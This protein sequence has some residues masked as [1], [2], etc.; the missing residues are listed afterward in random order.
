[1][2]D[3]VRVHRGAR[4][5]E[6]AL[7]AQVAELVAPIR[8]AR[9]FRG[10]TPLL[11]PYLA[12]PVRV[13]VPSRSLRE[14]VAARLAR[15][16]GG[17][18]VGV[19]VQTLRGLAFEIV[20]RAGE[21][22]R[23]GHVLFPILVRQLARDEEALRAALEDLDDGYSAVAASVS[24][25]LDAGYEPAL[26]EGLLDCLA[27][28]G[29]A[30]GERARALARVAGQAARRLADYG[31][32][33][34]AG[35]F[36][37]AREALEADAERLLHAR[38]I[39][40]HGYADATGVQ[41]E[42][43]RALRTLG[44]AEI[45]L[46]HPD[47][48]AEPGR[49]DPGH[50][51]TERLAS[52][53][54]LG[55]TA[56]E[57]AEVAPAP[58]IELFRA[59]GAQ[60][61][62]REVAERIRRAID[63][64]GAPEDLAI[65]ARD[66]GP[67]RLALETQ[68]GRLAIP[69]SGGRGSLTAAGRRLRALL[70]LLRD[71]A[72][73]AG[74]RWLDA[75]DLFDAAP[76]RDLRLALHG[77]GLGRVRDVAATDP[78]GVAGEYGYALPVR[79]GLFELEAEDG[80]D[81]D[82]AEAESTEVVAD[83]GAPGALPKR[84]AARAVRRRLRL[85]HLERAVER[86]AQLVDELDAL[87]GETTLGAI[88]ARLRRMLTGK[89]A[90]GWKPETAG[91]SEAHG[92]LAALEEEIGGGVALSFPEARLLLESALADAGR[93]PLGGA[94]G[95]VAILSVVEARARTF[96]R[97][98]VLGMNRD[99]FPRAIAEDP[100]LPDAD[101]VCIEA[102]LPDV[103][104]KRRGFTEERYLFAQLCSAAPHVCLSWQAVSDDGKE[105]LASPL[106]ERLLAGRADAEIPLAPPV[107]ARRGDAL[108]PAHEHAA[109][110]ALAGGRGVRLERLLA[111]SLAGGKPDA[112]ATLRAHARVAAIRELDEAGHRGLD[113]GPY[114]GFVGAIGDAAD[115]RSD[116][117]WVTALEGL[118][119]CGW[120]TFLRRVLRV[121]PVPDALEALP[122]IDARVIG[123]VLHAALEEIA[124]RA[125]VPAGVPLAE[126][127]A[128]EPRDVAWP[129]AAALDAI[130]LGAAE[131]VARE[132]GIALAGFPRDLDRRV[133][134]FLDRARALDWPAG[135]LRGVV[136]VELV[137]EARGA[138]GLAISFRADRVDRRAGALRLT[139][140]KAGKPFTTAKDAADRRE[141]LL[142]RIGGGTHL[143][144]F[145]YARGAGEDAALGRYLY[146]RPD[147]ADA[148]AEVAIEPRDAD[149]EARFESAAGALF[150]AY[151]QG[152]FAPRLLASNRKETR[153]DCTYCEVSAAC[154]QGSS[155]A[156]RR[157]ARWLE[158]HEEAAPGTPAEAAALAA[159]RLVDEER[160]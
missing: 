32:E 51:F 101:R 94:G 122:R 3:G 113:L 136:G 11:A 45:G 105:R 135:V 35:L 146:V 83:A 159:L 75:A 26:E 60:A 58:E 140:Y 157:L 117:L 68:L 107:V 28:L 4:A 92:A 27:G 67:Y 6:A 90:L 88:L 44:G 79:R 66:L 118:A 104:I 50:V 39:L 70:D 13:V 120:Q 151:E 1:M 8:E 81:G 48:P 93:A 47:D 95:G 5:T 36:R 34:R 110:A 17:A 143:Q 41:L 132:E 23:G 53:L 100:L 139:D 103:P 9:H 18:A 160:A 46:D 74:D 99:L 25:L 76:L 64:G 112:E 10:A 30:R 59:S 42:L 138:S 15:A 96:E 141:A 102:V 119:R 72:E 149:A 2:G 43:L 52:A 63:A 133:R 111:I 24:D 130:V 55:R 7:V 86:A 65:V 38:A 22:A 49:T 114:F 71:G 121:E 116:A 12:K 62:A 20:G 69:F 29:G 137:G 142:K 144:A 108:R 106:V 128:A 98:Y 89:G 150:A 14:H 123:Q 147:L 40:I 73:A 82:D 31:L 129:D 80:D 78:R 152:G 155:G 61:E 154:V 87:H 158:A 153:S 84:R 125:G 16:Q 21:T 148:A 97:V 145:A 19:V 124:R 134:P 57:D 56:V 33:H 156:R 109:R 77:I 126:A 91:F 54:A 115:P 37:R 131:S 85:H 127:L